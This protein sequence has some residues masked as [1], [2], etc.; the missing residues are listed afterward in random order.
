MYK[1]SQ[2]ISSMKRSINKQ[3][4]SCIF[5]NNKLLHDKRFLCNAVLSGYQRKITK[6]D[7]SSSDVA[8]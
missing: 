4:D 2:S 5:R 8:N 6:H 3:K 1:E 7:D